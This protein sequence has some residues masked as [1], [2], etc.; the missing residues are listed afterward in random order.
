MVFARLILFV[1]LTATSTGFARA[2][3][4]TIHG[5]GGFARVLPLSQIE[6][7]GVIEVKDGREVTIAGQIQRVEIRYGGVPLV[8]VLEARG[9][10]HARSL[11]APRGHDPAHGTRR[12]SGELFLG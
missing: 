2:Q 1:F 6:A 9:Y 11:Q 12:L 10:R 5:I 3:N 7:L 8:K 4:L